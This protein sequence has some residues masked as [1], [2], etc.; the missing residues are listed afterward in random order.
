MGMIYLSLP[1]YL[2]QT[3][4]VEECN[5]L[6]GSERGQFNISRVFCAYLESR[7]TLWY[8][9]CPTEPCTYNRYNPC[10]EITRYRRLDSLANYYLSPIDFCGLQ[11]WVSGRL[12]SGWL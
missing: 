5:A 1:P 9:Q 11:T 10:T 6:L 4:V 8:V 2:S 7:R 12:G 3:L